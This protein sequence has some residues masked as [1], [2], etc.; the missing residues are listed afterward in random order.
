M[1]KALRSQLTK[2]FK[3][4]IEEAFKAMPGILAGDFEYDV[5]RIDDAVDAQLGSLIQNVTDTTKDDIGDLVR[6]GLAEGATINEMQRQI[7]VKHSFDAPR[8]LAISRTETT[9]SVNAGGISAWEQQAA[10][11]GVEVIFRWNA[12][13]GARTAH[14]ALNNEPRGEDGYWHS[15]GAKAKSPGSFEGSSKITAALNINCRCN[16]KPEVIL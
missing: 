6:T 1:D 5:K 9:K 8:A 4:S 16:F 10:D 7:M 11:A 12:Q 13:P 15:G 14:A 3:K 2:A